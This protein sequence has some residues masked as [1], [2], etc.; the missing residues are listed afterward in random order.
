[1][2]AA[3]KFLPTTA[4]LGLILLPSAGCRSDWNTSLPRID[5]D[6][7]ICSEALTVRTQLGDYLSGY[8]AEDASGIRTRVIFIALELTKY[9]KN[10]RLTL[11]GNFIDDSVRLPDGDRY[12]VLY[13]VFIVRKASPRKMEKIPDLESGQGI[14]APKR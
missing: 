13:R 10:E 5:L 4:V 12:P 6:V 14:L 8:L 2:T 11:R 9:E 3:G 1:M 7:R